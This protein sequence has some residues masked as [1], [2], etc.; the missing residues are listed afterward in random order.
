MGVSLRQFKRKNKITEANLRVEKLSDQVNLIRDLEMRHKKLRHLYDSREALA[1]I[2]EEIISEIN[3][4][5]PDKP[6]SSEMYLTLANQEKLSSFDI[7]DL[8]KVYRDLILEISSLNNR[9]AISLT[10]R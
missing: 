4:L 5:P 10:R 2:L 7:R 6:L 1:V 8:C 9:N 3:H